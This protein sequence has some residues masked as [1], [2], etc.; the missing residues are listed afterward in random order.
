MTDSSPTLP[1]DLP[2]V[3]DS[4]PKKKRAKKAPVEEMNSAQ[5]LYRFLYGACDILRGPISQDN[6][7]EC[8]T[9][10]LYYKRIS[11]V[12]DEESRR[13]LEES[14]GDKDYASLPEMH[15][16]VIPDGCHW[17]DIRQR[18]E[19]VGMALVTALRQIE[20]A[21]P[22]TLWG[23]LSM[24]STQRLTDKKILSDEKMINLIE[25]LSKRC[26][27]NSH[28]GADLMG[29]AYEILLK[30]FADDSKAQAGEF[31]TPRSVIKLLVRIL[32]PQP[33]ET[34]YD[35]ACGSGGMLI[36]AIHHMKND[37]LCC[38]SIFGQ[39]K[40][41][42][43]AAIAKMNLFLHGATDFNIIRGDTLRNPCILQGGALAHF[44]CVI[45]NPPFSLDK[46]G[47]EAWEAD[48]Y[49]RNVWGTP[50]ESCGDFA[51]IQHMVKSMKPGRGR[52]AVVMPQGVLFRG[53]AEGIIRQRLVE[54]DMID[55]V[56]TLGDKLFY[57]TQLSPCF[58]ILRSMKP[59]HKSGRILMIDGSKILTPRRAQNELT[60]AD[61]DRLYNLYTGYA[62]VEDYSRVV[63][64][65]E[66]KRNDFML[67][68]TTYVQ[69]HK[70]EVEPHESVLARFR[71]ALAEVER[72]EQEFSNIM[73][74]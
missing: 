21:N 26:L 24:F 17:D 36:E 49:G 45:A 9:P 32:D 65:D 72:R 58:L 73:N 55:A 12:Y 16:F 50:P 60:D 42:V 15:S 63:T 44:D 25:H 8:I 46:W 33:G 7:K 67:S 40:N 51:W 43:N 10:L 71:E 68:P 1:L 29:D 64:F 61:I 41:P 19:D 62:D 28:Y 2:P 70:E 23:V 18:S 14:G 22:D 34:V 31:Y 37:E 11:D 47:A 57:G 4:K 39:E 38:G 53:K 48:P 74:R 3:E 54:S 59:A 66:I 56:V 69:Y 13:A 6:F 20:I 30:K 5:D 27:D 52:V 35:P